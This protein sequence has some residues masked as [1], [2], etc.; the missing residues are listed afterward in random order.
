MRDIH[1]VIYREG[2][3]WVAQALNV[4]VSS[5]GDTPQEARAALTEALE[6]YFEENGEVEVHEAAEPRLECLRV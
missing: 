6:L 2:A 4:D 1:A 3:H 5:F